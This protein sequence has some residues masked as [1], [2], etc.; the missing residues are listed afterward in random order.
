[1][2]EN[3]LKLRAISRNERLKPT[4][5]V[6]HLDR[7]PTTQEMLALHDA[8]LRGGLL[9]PNEPG[10]LESAVRNLIKAVNLTKRLGVQAHFPLE[11]YWV[12]RLAELTG[13][14]LA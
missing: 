1:M 7:T 9:A 10:E 6:L 13:Q 4:S 2:Q 12:K 14:D 5:L 8:L 11:N 3:P